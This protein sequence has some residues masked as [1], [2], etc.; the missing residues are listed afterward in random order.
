MRTKGHIDNFITELAVIVTVLSFSP[1]SAIESISSLLMYSLWGFLLVVK[2]CQQKFHIDNFAK[3]TLLFYVFWYAFTQVLY[4]ANVYP[5][6]GLGAASFLPYCVVFYVIGMNY[7]IDREGAIKRLV[8]A[9]VIGQIIL[10][11][12]LLPYLDEL[13]TEYYQFGAKN[14]MGQMLGLGVVFELFILNQTYD[15]IVKKIVLWGVSG[16]SL[17]SLMI[18][19]SRTPLIAVITVAI[20]S[21]VLKKEKSKKDFVTIGGVL[22]VATIAV[23]QLGGMAFLQDLFGIG[24]SNSFDD[25]TNGRGTL[26]QMAIRDFLNSPFVGRGGYAYVDNFVLNVLRCGGLLLGIVLIPLAYTKLFNSIKI[27]RQELL[28]YDAKSDFGLTFNT[29]QSM[30]V[31]YFVVSLMEG[32]PPLGPNTSVFFLWLIMGIGIQITKKN[33]A[34]T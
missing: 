21:F 20:F 32:S 23:T 26:Y 4:A 25:V 13:Q 9:F 18:I 11:I 16:L 31:F 8:R 24:S 17:F 33:G 30:A 14:Q 1:E 27:S 34:Q 29:L 10:M 12:T 3:G 2:A 15:G 28:I 7:Q 19:H 5:S 22:L 6:R